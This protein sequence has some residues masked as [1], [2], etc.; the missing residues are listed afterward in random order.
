MPSPKILNAIVG[1]QC[2]Y[3]PSMGSMIQV[4]RLG[5]AETPSPADEASSPMKAWSENAALRPFIRWF[6]TRVSTEKKSQMNDK[7]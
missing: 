2:L 7:C 6:S 5:N 1:K 3:L 4:G